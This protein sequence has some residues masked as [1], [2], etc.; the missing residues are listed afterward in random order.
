MAVLKW[1]TF[2]GGLGGT[3]GESPKA[4]A[5]YL[6]VGNDGVA[7]VSRAGGGLLVG[8]LQPVH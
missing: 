2:T 1:A 7:L 6:I 4:V 3:A 5:G 8:H